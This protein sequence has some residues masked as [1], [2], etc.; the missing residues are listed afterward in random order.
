MIRYDPTLSDLT[1]F[2]V[3]WSLARIL[4]KERVYPFQANELFQK[5]THIKV[6]I[7]HC[8]VFICGVHVYLCIFDGIYST[9]KAPITTA[10]DRQNLDIFL[11]FEKNK[12]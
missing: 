4:M 8:N 2:L 9:L 7:V 10:A 11:N 3:L 12:A 1:S 6:R 5:A